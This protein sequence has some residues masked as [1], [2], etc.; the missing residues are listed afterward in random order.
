MV[1]PERG[2]AKTAEPP[3]LAW[4]EL[5]EWAPLLRALLER[6]RQTEKPERRALACLLPLEFQPERVVAGW[7]SGRFAL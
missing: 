5:P 7:D 4:Q 2:L 1:T 3:G 6:E